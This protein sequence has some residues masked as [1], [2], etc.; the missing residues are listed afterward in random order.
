VID[1]PPPGSTWIVGDTI[2]FSGHASDSQD[3]TEP[4]ARLSWTV[5]LFH[6]P[7][8]CHTHPLQTFSGVAGGSFTAPDHEYPSYLEL[9]LTATDAQGLSA[10]TS[11][12]LNPQTVD[13]TFQSSPAGAQLTVGTF[14]GAAPFTRTVIVGSANSISAP[15]QSIG[16][17]SYVFSSWSDGGAQTHTIT[18]SSTPASY[19]ATFAPA[20][21]ANRP[22]VAVATANPTSGTVPLTVRFDG[23]G[24]SDPDGDPLTYS[25]DLNGDSVF[26]DSTAVAPTFT[27]TKPGKVTVRLRVTD[28]GGASSTA[29]V[30]VQP[31]KK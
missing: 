10:S 6:C 29:T 25:W 28:P 24:S 18:A 22:P 1:S 14:T 12:Q 26:G 30:S 8:N 23:S 27:Y 7:S 21:P 17:T 5:T 20:P 11:I 9:K 15:N 19:T 3:G 16:G 31:R 13:L 2:A 4:A